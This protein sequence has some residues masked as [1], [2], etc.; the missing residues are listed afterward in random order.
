MKD[1]QIFDTVATHLFIQG[2]RSVSGSSCRYWGEDGTKCAAGALITKDFYFPELE[3]SNRTISHHVKDNPDKFPAWFLTNL[4]LIQELQTVHDRTYNWEHPNNLH[5]SLVEVA[6][7]YN[8]SPDILE[9]MSYSW[10]K[11]E[12]TDE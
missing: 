9:N 6:L 7:K 10:K 2:R 12:K 1:Q 4:G 8:L 3:M 11:E 5:N